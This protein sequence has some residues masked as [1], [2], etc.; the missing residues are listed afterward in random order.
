MKYTVAP[1]L[2]QLPE[3]G[4]GFVRKTSSPYMTYG[5]LPLIEAVTWAAAST[6]AALTTRYPGSP[7]LELRLEVK[8]LNTADGKPAKG[9][10]T[11][12]AGGRNV[13]IGYFYR[14]DDGTIAN[15]FYNHAK[16]PYRVVKGAREL[17]K[18]HP[19]WEF[20]A[21]WVFV[22]ELLRNPRVTQ[23]LTD[24]LY[25]LEFEQAARLALGGAE[26]AH[27]LK[28]IQFLGNHDNHFHLTVTP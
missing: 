28:T 21:N 23:I 8:D 15:R 18:V 5:S 6:H 12:G 19:R 22:L 9:H 14:L 4:V 11:H 20:E 7:P 10:K 2:S 25:C 27:A 24:R 1:G 3:E 17:A 13:D 26:L 16:M